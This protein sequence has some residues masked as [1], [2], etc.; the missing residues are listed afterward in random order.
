MPRSHSDTGSEHAGADRTGQLLRA[1]AVVNASVCA[2]LLLGDPLFVDGCRRM[3]CRDF[4]PFRLGS[5]LIY[6]LGSAASLLGALCTRSRLTDEQKTGPGRACLDDAVFWH[7][8]SAVAASAFW[9]RAFAIF[10]A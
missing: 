4:A 1:L 8:A 7:G 3:L 5:L 6:W 2:L 10:G 9:I